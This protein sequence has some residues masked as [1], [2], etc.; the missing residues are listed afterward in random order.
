MYPITYIT[1]CSDGNARARLSTRIGALFGQSPTIVAAD[2]PD[3]ESFAALTLLDCLRSTESLGEDG[4]P[5]ITLAQ[6]RA[7]RW[8]LAQRRTVLLFLGRTALVASTFNP[9]ALALVRR[10]LDV[11]KVLRH[12]HPRGP[13][14]PRPGRTSSTAEVGQDRGHPVPQPLVPAAARQMGR[15]RPPGP[16]DTDRR[17]TAA[18][19]PPTVS[20][21]DNFGNC[22]LNCHPTTI[23]CRPSARRS[24]SPTGPRSPATPTSPPFPEAN[25][26]PHPRQLR[27]RLPGTRRPQRLRCPDVQPATRRHASPHPRCDSVCL[28]VE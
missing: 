17:T 26:R 15:R 3:P 5:T 19:E 24:S 18:D 14:A 27:H 23:H 28:T 16:V 8:R 21:I 7:P 6:H 13:R 9:R 2:G 4:H 20:V 22:K 1:D 11:Q 12:G 10:E 25:P